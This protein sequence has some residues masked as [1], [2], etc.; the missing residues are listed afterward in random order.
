[1]NLVTTLPYRFLPLDCTLDPRKPETAF[2]VKGTFAMQHWRHAAPVAAEDQIDLAG[3]TP[4]MDEIG[5]SLS[6]A[7]DLVPFKPFGEITLAGDCHAPDGAAATEVEVGLEIGKISKRLKVFGDRVWRHDATGRLRIEGPA[8]FR[9]MPLRWERAFGGLGVPEN[10][11]GRGVDPWTLEDGRKVLFL[12]NIEQ[13]A[14]PIRL[15][16]QRGKPVCFAPIS[17][18]WQPRLGREGTRDQHWATFIA[19]LP[20]RDH[21]VR[22]AQA[23]PD[24]QWS[25]GYWAGDER[26]DLHNMHPEHGHYVTALPAMRLRLFVEA[27]AADGGGPAFG[28]I[29]LALDTIHVDMAEERLVLVWRQRYRPRKAGAPEIEHAYLVEE[30]LGEPP[31]STEKHHADFRAMRGQG[32]DAEGEQMKLAE[33][34]ALAQA[35]K[36]LVD[37]GI[38]PGT[39]ARFDAAPDAHAKFEMITDLIRTKTSELETMTK[40]LKAP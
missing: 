19:P 25:D 9:R 30:P 6:C 32:V 13:P 4:F 38:E 29:P 11:M 5:R 20:P 27:A 1:M 39:I 33:E 24:D 3:D 37:A 36:T 34:R 31:G 40:A 7:S 21:D 8:P 2:I 17:P 23:A 22:A 14:N 15:R 12:A 28:E 35:R 26:I 10:P 18:Q 16:E